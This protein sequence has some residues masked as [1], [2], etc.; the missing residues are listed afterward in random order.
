MQ[1]WR[2]EHIMTCEDCG[3]GTPKDGKIFCTKS[4]ENKESSD[5]CAR[6][7]GK[8]YDGSELLSPEMHLYLQKFEEENRKISGSRPFNVGL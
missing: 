4:S 8:R 6:Y 1:K 7:F 5:K 2:G 3:I